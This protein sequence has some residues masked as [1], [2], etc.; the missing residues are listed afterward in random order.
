MTG[1][2]EKCHTY[3]RIRIRIHIYICSAIPLLSAPPWN[4]IFTISVPSPRKGRLIRKLSHHCKFITA[5]SPLK[6]S[7]Y[8]S[9]QHIYIYSRIIRCKVLPHYILHLP[10]P[11]FHNA[12]FLFILCVVKRDI[13]SCQYTT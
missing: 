2:M 10:V 13:I 1:E 7:F 12:R 8:H 6:T 5:F 11:P 3:L 9:W 4:L